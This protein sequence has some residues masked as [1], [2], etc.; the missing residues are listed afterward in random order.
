[1]DPKLTDKAITIADSLVASIKAV[2][3]QMVE[4]T[5]S[6]VYFQALINLLLAG[7][8]VV[9]FSIILYACYLASKRAFGMREEVKISRYSDTEVK[10]YFPRKAYCIWWVSGVTSFGSIIFWIGGMCGLFNT[11][12]WMAVID[13]RMAVAW[14]VISKAL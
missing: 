3:P 6:A 1:M 11:L 9:V 8:C 7:V 4:V 10:E 13:P 5:F 14:A 12:N 2:A